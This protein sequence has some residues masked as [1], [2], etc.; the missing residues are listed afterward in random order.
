MS[1]Q[2]VHCFIIDKVK[3]SPLVR[4]SIV[5]DCSTKSS[6]AAEALK[7]NSNIENIYFREP[8]NTGALVWIEYS[9]DQKN[10]AVI[11]SPITRTPVLLLKTGMSFIHFSLFQIGN[12]AY[13]ARIGVGFLYFTGGA[14]VGYCIG[15]LLREL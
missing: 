8:D 6:V 11:N 12:R 1:N 3:A 5:A 13:Y 2:E 10:L 4:V 7:L 14:I 9:Q 15:K